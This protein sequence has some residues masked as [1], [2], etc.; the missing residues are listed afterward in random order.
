MG[1]SRSEVT[2]VQCVTSD[3]SM[4]GQGGASDRRWYVCVT[5]GY[6]LNHRE[7]LNLDMIY[8]EDKIDK[9]DS[10]QDKELF[11]CT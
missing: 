2:G 1:V 4:I 8:V 11:T 7:Q 5:L 10:E 3:I 6:Y 9:Q